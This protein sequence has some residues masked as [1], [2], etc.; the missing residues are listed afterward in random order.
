MPRAHFAMVQAD[1]GVFKK[2]VGFAIYFVLSYTARPT[3]FYFYDM[4]QL[5]GESRAAFHFL[6]STLA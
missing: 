2:G 1:R 3:T 5:F 4:L 6:H